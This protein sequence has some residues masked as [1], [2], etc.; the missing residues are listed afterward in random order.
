MLAAVTEPPS[1]H[2]LNLIRLRTVATA[3]IIAHST[4]INVVFLFTKTLLTFQ[5]RQ[6]E[7]EFRPQFVP[8]V[9]GEI[10]IKKSTPAYTQS[11]HDISYAGIIQIRSRVRGVNPPHLSRVYSAPRIQL[12]Q[13]YRTRPP[14]STI[15][16]EEKISSPRSDSSAVI[17]L[18]FMHYA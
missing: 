1:A 18:C 3:I 11:A 15:K 9:M 7:S 16:R 12:N 13:L 14:V 10:G 17:A 5:L 6:P 4:R 2:K 8:V